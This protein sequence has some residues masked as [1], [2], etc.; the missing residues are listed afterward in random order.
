[1]KKSMCQIILEQIKTMDMQGAVIEEIKMS[2]SVAKR[3]NEELMS[4][5]DFSEVAMRL[6]MIK[7]TVMLSYPANEMRLIAKKAQ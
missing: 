7:R 6:S 5:N 4:D 1:M 3:I 2:Q